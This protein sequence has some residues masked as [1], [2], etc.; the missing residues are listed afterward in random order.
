MKL[1]ILRI[2]IYAPWVIFLFFLIIFFETQLFC[3]NESLELMRYL[4]PFSTF[5]RGRRGPTQFCWW[6]RISFFLQLWTYKLGY[7]S[8]WTSKFFFCFFYFWS[9]HE[10][11]ESKCSTKANLEYS[12]LGGFTPDVLLFEWFKKFM[13]IKWKVL[14]QYSQVG[15]GSAHWTRLKN[16]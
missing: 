10:K 3:S 1:I 13:L 8:N 15:C 12:I 16:L 14:Q 6:M 7:N 11:N 2:N 4:Y 5:L 9:Q